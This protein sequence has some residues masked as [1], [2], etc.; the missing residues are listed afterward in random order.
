MIGVYMYETVIV[1]G[2]YNKSKKLK[3]FEKRKIV[4]VFL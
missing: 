4:E 2:T 3:T 1:I